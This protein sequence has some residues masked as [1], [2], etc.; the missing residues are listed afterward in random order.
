MLEVD[1]IIEGDYIL[2]M[3]DNFTIM[4]ESS[5][6]IKGDKIVDICKKEDAANTYNAKELIKGVQNVLLPGLINT[7]T[8]APMVY[9]RGLADDLP[10]KEWLENYIWP[11]ENS[12]LSPSFVY[13]AVGLAC[14]EMLKAGVTTYN[15]MYFF[16]DVAGEITK[17]IGMR[18]VLGAGILDFPSVS[19]K[20]TDEYLNNA[21]EFISRW[22]KDDLIIPSVAPHALYTCNSDT[23]KKAKD[24][25][26]RFDVPLHIHLSETKW[27]VEEI[28][29]KYNMKPVEY[30]EKIGFLDKRVLAAHCIWL[31]DKEIEILAKRQVGVS[32]CIESNLKLASGFAPIVKMINSG[33][34]V[35]F[36]TDGAASNNDLNILSEISTTAKLQ[37][38]LSNNPTVLNA[39]TALLMATKWASQCLGLESKIGTIEIGKKADI[40]SINL[41]KPHL[42]PIYDICSHIVYSA[43]ASDVE[44]VMVNGRLIMDKGKL[45]TYDESEIL[46]KSKDWNKKI[47]EQ[48]NL[49]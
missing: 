32:H 6:V 48:L 20:T 14:L 2:T 3:D 39:K 42:T 45:I 40:I 23:L 17:K 29:K 24:L 18:A 31:D 26:E 22:I 21:K 12:L 35:S 30:L 8:H 41:A 19:A 44:M 34:K 38:A 49:I 27:E 16:E 4:K 43:M 33:I 9:F 13:D 11:A 7:H 37:K 5:I 28:I 25:A 1:Y 46:N 47:I 15:D 10:L 36:G